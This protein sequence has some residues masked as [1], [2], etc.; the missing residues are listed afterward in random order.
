MIGTVVIEM[1]PYGVPSIHYTPYKALANLPGMDLVYRAW[2][3]KHEETS[4]GH[5]DNH[6]LLGGI[7]KLSKEMQEKVLSTHSVPQH[8]C[9]ES[10]YWLYRI[11]QDTYVNSDEIIQ[12]INEELVVSREQLK[13]YRI[14]KGKPVYILP[15]VISK[16]EC[17][18]VS[19]F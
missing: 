7:R 13:S 5:P 14:K 6:E 3:N 12:I 19:I 9:C 8:V 11:Y 18:N 10:P 4:V 16:V 17:V 15:P 1:F 2:E